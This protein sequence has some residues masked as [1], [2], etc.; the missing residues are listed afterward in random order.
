MSP[1]FVSP[2]AAYTCGVA[3]NER[4]PRRAKAEGDQLTTRILELR[5]AYYERDELL[6]SDAEYDGMMRRLE[7]LERM[8]PELQGQDSPTQTVGGRAQTTLFDPG[9]HRERMLSLDNVFSIEEFLGWAVRVENPP[10]AW[11]TTFAN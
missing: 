10:A 5:D 3:D 7:E 11:S 8:F 9:T 1:W 4:T 6:V 2:Y